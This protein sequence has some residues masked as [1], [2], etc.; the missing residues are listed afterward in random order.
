[1]DKERVCNECKITKP[2]TEF[3]K[4]RD[5]FT[6]R[7]K[8]CVNKAERLRYKIK[9]VE[10][11]K[12]QCYE[13]DLDEIHDELSLPE[14]KALMHQHNIPIKAHS[15]K[16]ELVEVLEQKGILP[17]NYVSGIRRAVATPAK[18]GKRLS[19]K[20]VELTDMSD[21]SV[22]IFPSLYKTAKFLGT[23]NHNITKHNGLS[24][25]TGADKTYMIKIL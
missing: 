23:Y 3:H 4:R 19:A 9:S 17:E 5:D 14:L 11:G 13:V 15:N 25:I 8:E 2:L 12:Y 24:F 7:C 22:I 1:M 16:P 10:N 21:G 20:A 18:T 6:K